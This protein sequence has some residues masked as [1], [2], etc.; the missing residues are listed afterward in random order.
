MRFGKRRDV[1]TAETWIIGGALNRRSA[2]L[3][4]LGERLAKTA[5]RAAHSANADRPIGQQVIYWDRN[6][7]KYPGRHR[8][9]AD[10][11]WGDGSRRT[12]RTTPA[13]ALAV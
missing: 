12:D 2:Q 6:D 1:P 13:I 7:P 11:Y 5:I 9:L 8:S 3:F 4:E 10:G